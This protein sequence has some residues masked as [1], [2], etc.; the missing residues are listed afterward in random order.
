[1]HHR[2]A[3]KGELAAARKNCS[4]VELQTTNG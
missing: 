1:V 4:P 2:T 3:V